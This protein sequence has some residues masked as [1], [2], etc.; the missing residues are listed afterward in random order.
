DALKI[1]LSALCEADPAVRRFIE[2]NVRT[3]NGVPAE[4][5]SFDALHALIKGQVYRLAFWR[6]AADDINYRRFFDINDL[7]ALRAERPE[8]F[9]ATHRRILQLVAR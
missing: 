6:V 2:A 7:A 3:I 4:P 5:A 9:E 8:V 1:A